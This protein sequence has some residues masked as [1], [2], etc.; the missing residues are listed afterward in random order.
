MI[1]S[2]SAASITPICL[3]IFPVQ[4]RGDL[5][6]IAEFLAII[7]HHFVIASSYEESSTVLANSKPQLI[8]VNTP[9]AA[10]SDQKLLTLIRTD[11]LLK[12]ARVIALTN[13]RD[14]KLAIRLV[15]A[16]RY[17]LVFLEVKEP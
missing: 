15:E 10:R 13:T 8:F 4:N 12:R 3:V 17:A 11:E 9:L 5:P 7:G 6:L 16:G 1:P 2:S 14:Q